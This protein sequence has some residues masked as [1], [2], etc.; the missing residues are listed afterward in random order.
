MAEFSMDCNGMPVN[1]RLGDHGLYYGTSPQLKGLLVTGDSVDQVMERVP[2][3]VAEI[4]AI[5]ELSSLKAELE[6]AREII[7]LA[8]CLCLGSDWNKGTH[9]KAYRNKLITAV[10]LMKPLPS[11]NFIDEEKSDG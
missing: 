10:N 9:A 7:N 6:E 11:L 8:Y 1:I 2:S 4:R 3:A 5:A